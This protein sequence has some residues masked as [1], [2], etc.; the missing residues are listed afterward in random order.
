MCFMCVIGVKH[1]VNHRF[2]LFRSHWKC[3]WLY[4]KASDIQLPLLPCALSVRVCVPKAKKPMTLLN[5]TLI[6]PLLGIYWSTT[7]QVLILYLIPALYWTKIRQIF[8]H[9]DIL[10]RCNWTL[11]HRSHLQTRSGC[12]HASYVAHNLA[13][14]GWRKLTCL[15]WWC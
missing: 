10:C 8:Q 15:P 12:H 2:T 14:E 3:E 7:I 9:T 1:G 11:Q 5:V 4:I 6:S 13:T